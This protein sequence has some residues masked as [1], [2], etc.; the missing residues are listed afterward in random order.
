MI[1]KGLDEKKLRL[2]DRRSGPQGSSLG[3]ARQ[4][5]TAH[6]NETEREHNQKL[7]RFN[8]LILSRKIL[9]KPGSQTLTLRLLVII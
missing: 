7:F 4:P 2:V 1:T 5:P 9:P 8:G 3:P 6:S